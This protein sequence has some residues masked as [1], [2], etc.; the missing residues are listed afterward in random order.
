[1]GFTL[2]EDED[3]FWGDATTF[4][5]ELVRSATRRAPRADAP[6]LGRPT[7]S[8]A[9][10][11]MYGPIV[12]TDGGAHFTRVL[13]LGRSP[14]ALPVDRPRGWMTGPERCSNA[15]SSPSSMDARSTRRRRSETRPL[16][17]PRDASVEISRASRPAPS[18]PWVGTT[19]R[20]T[21]HSPSRVVCSIV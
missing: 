1:M 4:G 10:L 21:H 3:D 11:C 8:R 7:C 12:S 9:Q 16:P 2:E 13:F 14:W 19:R 5:C 6:T 15:A 20:P 17:S 18:D